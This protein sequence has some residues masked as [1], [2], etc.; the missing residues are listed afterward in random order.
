MRFGKLRDCAGATLLEVLVALGI[1]GLLSANIIKISSVSG[2]WVDQAWKQNQAAALAFG[3]LDYYRST[4]DLLDTETFSGD[5]A[6]ELL[7][8]EAYE[9]HLYPWEVVCQPWD[10][11]ALL[12]QIQVRVN[13]DGGQ[14]ENA[15]HMC[16]LL[17]APP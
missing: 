2:R 1:L 6:R 9:E 13:W 7:T 14:T 11:E 4:P 10:A 15:V 8:Q 3:I 5:D 12:W 17:Y 16:T